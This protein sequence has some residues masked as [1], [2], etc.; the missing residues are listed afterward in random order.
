MSPFFSNTS[1]G[2]VQSSQPLWKH[3]ELM[4]ERKAYTGL[5]MRLPAPLTE[6]RTN[7]PVK[8]V[9]VDSGSDQHFDV[10]FRREQVGEAFLNIAQGNDLGDNAFGIYSMLPQQFQAMRKFSPID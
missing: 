6:R 4:F 5:A 10:V 7:Y 3:S 8:R 9:N 2:T 1:S